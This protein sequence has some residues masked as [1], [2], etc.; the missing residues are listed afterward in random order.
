MKS[1]QKA[2]RGVGSGGRSARLS[3]GTA[4]GL[5]TG[6]HA[7]RSGHLRVAGVGAAG[8]SRLQTSAGRKEVRLTGEMSS[9]K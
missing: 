4:F 8:E 2:E 6:Y 9:R 1:L 7:A 3:A 5:F